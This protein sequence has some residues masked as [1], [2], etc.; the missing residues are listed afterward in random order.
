MWRANFG[1]E[2][3]EDEKGMEPPAKK[4]RLNEVKPRVRRDAPRCASP[5]HFLVQERCLKENAEESVGG[6]SHRKVVSYK[7]QIDNIL[8][9][10]STLYYQPSHVCRPRSQTVPRDLVS[11]LGQAAETGVASTL[12]RVTYSAAAALVSPYFEPSVFDS[13]TTKEIM[14]F[15]A[16]IISLGKDFHAIQKLI[17][18]KTTKELVHFFYFWKQSAHYAMWKAHDH[19]SRPL[20]SG[21]Q[22]QWALVAR[23]LHGESNIDQD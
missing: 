23:Q 12:D 14:L 6:A 8:D 20:P 21:K 16:G 4:L 22:E 11:F 9:A 1:L 13:W 5:S 2:E 19:P 3:K 10:V 18:T 17:P 7:R 15:E